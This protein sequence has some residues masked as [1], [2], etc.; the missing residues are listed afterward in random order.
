MT[1]DLRRLGGTV[2][3]GAIKG[4]LQWHRKAIS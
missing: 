1:S 2:L 3:S 4:P